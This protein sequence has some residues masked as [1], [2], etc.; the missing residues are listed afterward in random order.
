MTKLSRSEQEEK[1]FER[2]INNYKYR[3]KEQIIFS[4]LEIKASSI[5]EFEYR[6]QD[7]TRSGN[8]NNN[9]TISLSQMKKILST[10]ISNNS[11]AK[12][13]LNLAL[14]RVELALEKK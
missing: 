12:E 2:F 4:L 8:L 11:P 13:Y 14:Q 9:S 6:L 1:N 10:L 3:D 5:S 7:A